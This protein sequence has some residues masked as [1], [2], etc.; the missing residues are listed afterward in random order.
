MSIQGI[1][2]NENIL[3][4]NEMYLIYKHCIIQIQPAMSGGL[5]HMLQY[6]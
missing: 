2:Y 4:N 5:A 6:P 1:P 3:L